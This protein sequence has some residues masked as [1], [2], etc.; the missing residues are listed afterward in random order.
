MTDGN[1][2]WGKHDLGRQAS[3]ERVHGAAYRVSARKYVVRLVQFGVSCVELLEC[4]AAT[5]AISLAEDAN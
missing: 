3:D 4:G 5:A 2:I 1:S